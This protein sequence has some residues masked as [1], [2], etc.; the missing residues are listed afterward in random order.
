MSPGTLA[1]S[2]SDM[3][4]ARPPQEMCT[5]Y[6]MDLQELIACKPS[7]SLA[8]LLRQLIASERACKESKGGAPP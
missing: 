4:S 6:L 7:M 5:V 8:M 2:C 3:R 1:K